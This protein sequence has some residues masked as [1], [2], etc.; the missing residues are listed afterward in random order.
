MSAGQSLTPHVLLALARLPSHL[1]A[2]R[3]EPAGRAFGAILSFASERGPIGFAT[4]ALDYPVYSAAMALRCL[5]LL[6]PSGWQ[7][8]AQPLDA[9]LRS[10]Q[11]GPEWAGHPAEGG[12]SMGYR[13]RQNPP[14]AGHVDLSMTRRALE[15]LGPGAGDAATFLERCRATDGGFVYSPVE[16]VLNKGKTPESA[17][18]SAT[19]D[20]V[21]ACL[22]LGRRDLAE[23]G[24]V[25]LRDHHR[26]DENPGVSR[27]PRAQYAR[28]M[29]GY[30]RAGAA[31]C[32]A[33]VGGP[34]GWQTRMIDA[35]VGDQRDDGSWSNPDPLQKE[36]DPLVATPLAL[37]ALA[38]A[39]A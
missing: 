35:I 27:G 12:F 29:V 8:A 3:P 28:A 31:R 39:L 25:W 16:R 20:G 22:A 13:E 30:Y 38:A 33:A 21:L 37:T 19:S 17:Y 11:F 14:N 10:Q 15:A 4:P 18:G 23:T 2:L 9:W 24:I 26:T 1:E 34:E 36:D 5:T 6:K 32:F 7:Q